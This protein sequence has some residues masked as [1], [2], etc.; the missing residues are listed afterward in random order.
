MRQYTEHDLPAM[1]AIWN[2]V[3]EEGV[4]F[5]QEH[6]LDELTGAAFLRR[7]HTALWRWTLKA[8]GY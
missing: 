3:V 7:N 1:L 8:A 5:P 4:A 6:V 2:E